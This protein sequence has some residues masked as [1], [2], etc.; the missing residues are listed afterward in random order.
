MML[1]G[2]FRGGMAVVVVVRGGCG[3]WWWWGRGREVGRM[4]KRG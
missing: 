4:R 3:L 2:V 1:K